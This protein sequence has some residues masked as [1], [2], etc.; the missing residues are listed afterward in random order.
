MLMIT[1]VAASDG[2]TLK[3]EGKLLGPWVDE[4]QTACA[5]AGQKSPQTRLDLTNVTY[6]D[7]AGRDLLDALRASGVAIVA[8]SSFV[9][10]LL[11]TEK[12]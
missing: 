8:C 1:S 11:R 10:E 6:M 12:P 5:Q 3:V 7:L 9:A 2:I 4:L